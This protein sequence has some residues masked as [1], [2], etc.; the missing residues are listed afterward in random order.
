VLVDH[1]Q[2]TDVVVGSGETTADQ[3]EQDSVERM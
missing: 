3:D 2:S 1:D